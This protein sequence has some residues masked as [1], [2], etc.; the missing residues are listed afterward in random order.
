MAVGIPVISVDCPEPNEV[1]GFGK[2]GYLVNNNE[3][4]LYNGIKDVIDNKSLYENY[5]KKAIERGKMF[6][7]NGF[8]NKIEVI[9]DGN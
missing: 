9:L 5:R 6:S 1:L 4:D 8:I 2:Y 3:N 7:I